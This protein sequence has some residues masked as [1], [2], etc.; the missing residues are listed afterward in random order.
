MPSTQHRQPFLTLKPQG[1]YRELGPVGVAKS[2]FECNW[3]HSLTLVS[4]AEGGVIANAASIRV[5]MALAF[6]FFNVFKDTSP[7]ASRRVRVLQ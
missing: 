7:E 4:D 6:I 1:S 3:L 5:A 2:E